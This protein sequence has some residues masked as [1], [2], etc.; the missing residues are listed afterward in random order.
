M[1]Q[2]L[3]TIIIRQLTLTSLRWT[4]SKGD[5]AFWIGGPRHDHNEPNTFNGGYV[6]LETSSLAEGEQ[7][8]TV[9]IIITIIIIITLMT[10]ARP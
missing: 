5:D 7:D 10:R 6:F 4:P 9:R 3:V 1:T 2:S 8:T